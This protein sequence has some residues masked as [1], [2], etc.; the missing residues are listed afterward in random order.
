MKTI[1][2]DSSFLVPLYESLRQTLK[3]KVYNGNLPNYSLQSLIF[4]APNTV[5]KQ[6]LLEKIFGS[7]PPAKGY[8]AQQL[9][10]GNRENGTTFNIHYLINML[11][12]VGYNVSKNELTTN[13]PH[14]KVIALA[15]KFLKKEFPKKEQ[16]EPKAKAIVIEDKNHPNIFRGF[17]N[18]YEGK[19]Y[20]DDEIDHTELF[21]TIK[22]GNEVTGIVLMHYDADGIKK[23]YT[24]ELIVSGKIFGNRF[25]SLVYYNKLDPESSCGVIFLR[26]DAKKR[27]LIGDYVGYF[28]NIPKYRIECKGII[29]LNIVRK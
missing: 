26:H 8:L 18:K 1:K 24:H 22:N 27:K 16:L 3:V 12:Y 2:T 10:Y 13:S 19:V 21:Y 5:N 17:E 4:N 15:N 25:L 28:H 9:S 29:K 23:A 6:D 7:N 11:N 14:E 20:Q